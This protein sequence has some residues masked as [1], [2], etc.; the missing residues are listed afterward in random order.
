MLKHHSYYKDS[1][2]IAKCYGMSDMREEEFE[3]AEIQ[4][5]DELAQETLQAEA[6]FKIQR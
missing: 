6:S 1:D 3:K 5:Q 4:G 2:L